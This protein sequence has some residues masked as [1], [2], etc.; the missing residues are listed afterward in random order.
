MPHCQALQAV[1][2]QG[3]VSGNQ[4]QRGVKAW[5]YRLELCE[6]D[7]AK[8]S[9]YAIGG[10]AVVPIG[11]APEGA[12]KAGRSSIY[13]NRGMSESR[14]FFGQVENQPGAQPSA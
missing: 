9:S 14:P 5:R 6:A 7:V 11:Q 10:C 8:E 1:G 13:P 2:R 3:A 12:G 4:I